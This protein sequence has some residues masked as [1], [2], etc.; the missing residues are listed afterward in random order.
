MRSAKNSK[1]RYIL[2][3]FEKFEKKSVFLIK[4]ILPY[5]EL[6]PFIYAKGVLWANIEF[7]M[8]RFLFE[9]A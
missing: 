6:R 3:I 9:I 1:R 2:E 5:L 4:Y 8:I 7:N